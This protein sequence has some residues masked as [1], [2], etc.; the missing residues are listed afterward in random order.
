MNAAAAPYFV[1]EEPGRWRALFLAAVVHGILF[2]FLWIGVR[3]QNE[4]PVA[5]EAEVWD[6]QAQQAAPKETVVVPEPPK[7]AIEKPVEA[8]DI[9][10]EQ[11]KKRK[12]AALK[13]E[14]LKKEAERK[15]EIEEKKKLELKDKAKLATEKKAHDKQ[16]ADDLAR[17]LAVG[18][19]SN[20]NAVQSTGARGD[21]YIAL[22]TAKIQSKIVYVG[23]RNVPDNPRAIFKIEQ[24]PTGEIFSVRKI[25]SSGIPAY[26]A[27]VESA[28]TLSSPL[29]KRKNGTVERGLE[30]GFHVNDLH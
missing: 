30:V 21:D 12:A 8:P 2:A 22:I 18:L 25:K 28:I 7:P 6:M 29:P 16:F 24:L 14:E 13:A 26:D 3:W 27:A 4:T 15:K 9:V 17:S 19:G 23:D 11:E 10:L 1:P 5:V 20:G